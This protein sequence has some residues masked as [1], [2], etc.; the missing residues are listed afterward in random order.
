MHVKISH[1]F[2]LVIHITYLNYTINYTLL[3]ENKQCS[4]YQLSKPSCNT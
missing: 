4:P 1:V 3:S 2:N